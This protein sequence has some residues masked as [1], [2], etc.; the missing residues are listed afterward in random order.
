MTRPTQANRASFVEAVGQVAAAARHLVH[1]ITTKAPRRNREEEARK[2][3][4][5][6]ERRNATV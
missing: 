4:E 1:S 6:T 5:R 2:A 3:R